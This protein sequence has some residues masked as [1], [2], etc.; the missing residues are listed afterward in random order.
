MRGSEHAGFSEKGRAALARLAFLVL[1]ALVVSAM[2]CR[3]PDQSVVSTPG[4]A[5]SESGSDR[6]QSQ[7]GIEGR[8][9]AGDGKPI[10]G[11]FVQAESLDE[12]AQRIPEMAITTDDD[13]HYLWPLSPGRYRISVSA[14][15]YQPATQTA[16][17]E[18]G[19][20]TTLSF[21]LK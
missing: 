17:V 2:A 21:S 18:A 4:D 10:S 3:N 20:L 5:R 1:A 14:E 6:S 15:G 9:T 11:V 8:V 7:A 12:P 19:R 13:G 16:T